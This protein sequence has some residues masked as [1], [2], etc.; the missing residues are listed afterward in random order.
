M[1][2]TDVEN[3]PGFPEGDRGPEVDGA[4][5]ASSPRASAP[6]SSAPTSSASTSQSARSSLCTDEHHFE[7]QTVIIATGASARW[8]DLPSEHAL[9]NRGV[10]A[11]ATC[12]GYF[13]RN[14]DVA[15]VGGGDTAMEEAL[16]LAGLCKSV[17]VI[18]RRDELRASKIMA[19]ARARASRS[20]R[21]EWN[22]AVAEVQATSRRARSPRV[23][24]KNTDERRDAR[25]GREGPL[26]RDRPHAQHAD[27]Q[28]VSSSSTRT[29]TSAP[30]P[31][32]RRPASKACS[33]PATCRTTSTARP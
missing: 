4:L 15:V 8:L 27:L 14:Q 29:A 5:Q 26:H 32:P 6:R 19:E 1:I 28:R 2:T 33:P 12:D 21:F 17:T 18:H 31:A 30:S 22:A 23:M 9:Q 16:Y 25:A 10:S 7:A 24:L 3:Y 20:I 13:F 11:C